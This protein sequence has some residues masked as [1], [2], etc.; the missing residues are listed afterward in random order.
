MTANSRIHIRE[1]DEVGTLTATYVTSS[2]EGLRH[3]VDVIVSVL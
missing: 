2:S 1:T 3:R